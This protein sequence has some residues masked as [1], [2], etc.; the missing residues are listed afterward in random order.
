VFLF[1]DKQRAL[2]GAVEWRV[3]IEKSF[4]GRFGAETLEYFRSFS[5]RHKTV[6]EQRPQFQALVFVL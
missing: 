5:A 3:D 1:T 6:K 2:K 4:I